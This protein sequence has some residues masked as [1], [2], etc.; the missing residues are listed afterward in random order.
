MIH[1]VDSIKADIKT[2]DDMAQLQQLMDA[3]QV[4]AQKIRMR[5]CAQLRPGDRV[6]WKSIRL[7]G[8]MMSGVVTKVNRKTVAVLADNRQTWKVAPTL[9]KKVG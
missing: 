2:I 9:L 7:K 5:I 4:Q 1:V 6:E 3:I 8:T